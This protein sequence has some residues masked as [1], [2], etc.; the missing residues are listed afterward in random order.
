MTKEML[1]KLHGKICGMKTR[2][3]LV[4]DYT[5][6]DLHDGLIVYFK[7]AEKFVEFMEHSVTDAYKYGYYAGPKQHKYSASWVTDHWEDGEAW[8]INGYNKE[9]GEAQCTWEEI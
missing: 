7:T 2:K 8:F 4:F 1:N 3:E 5:T 9:F 6:N